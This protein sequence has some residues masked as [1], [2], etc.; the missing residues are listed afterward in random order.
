[1]LERKL[2]FH[3]SI[4]FINTAFP[5]CAPYKKLEANMDIKYRLKSIEIALAMNR[6]GKDR[7]QSAAKN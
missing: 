7:T 1:M 6:P 2:R 3:I 5:M 4:G